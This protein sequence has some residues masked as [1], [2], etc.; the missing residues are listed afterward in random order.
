MYHHPNL[1]E[2]PDAGPQ[3]ERR[4][5]TRT[6]RT[7]QMLAASL[8]LLVAG[9]VAFSYLSQGELRG[10]KAMFAFLLPAAGGGL[11][12]VALAN[13]VFPMKV[14]V[15]ADGFAVGEELCSW[16][17][18]AAVREQL[19]PDSN[20]NQLN[21]SVRRNDN[22][23]VRFFM[24]KLSGV[25][26]LLAIVHRNTH[27]RLLAESRAALDRG[28]WVSFGP[29]EMNANVL[30]AR[31]RELSWDRFS[32]VAPDDAG[33]VGIWELDRK[34]P[35]LDVA[36]GTVDNLRV[37]LELV[38]QYAPASGYSQAMT[39]HCHFSAAK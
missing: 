16:T 31:G 21:F 19:H 34:K 6:D 27:S 9:G 38:E 5:E 26:E 30:R 33:D 22:W 25:P 29:I 28:E 10:K 12:L 2:L 3:A 8:L 18:V 39:S 13:L 23:S 14:S 24:W 36:T 35:W 17:D 15:T 1:V 7:L 32:H 11:G 20:V 4:F 37:L